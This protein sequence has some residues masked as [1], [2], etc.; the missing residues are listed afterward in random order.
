M[1]G[2]CLRINGGLGGDVGVLGRGGGVRKD[3]EGNSETKK[4]LEVF[5]S[6]CL[7]MLQDIGM[8]TAVVDRVS[9]WKQ[10]SMIVFSLF[11]DSADGT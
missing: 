6:L 5:W 3:D 10:V 2:G 4:S 8:N 11:E 7:S 9:L 1:L